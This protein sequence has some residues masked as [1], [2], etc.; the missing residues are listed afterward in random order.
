M[1]TDKE[2]RPDYE[3]IRRIRNS[4]DA[5]ISALSEIAGLDPKSDFQF[6]DLRGVDWRD[7][8]RGD[9][10][11]TG[12]LLDDSFVKKA[13]DEGH[14]FAGVAV[15]RQPIVP[16]PNLVSLDV[17]RTDFDIGS[18]I[19][20]IHID[21]SFGTERFF[22]KV[23]NKTL[24]AKVNLS[25]A[26]IVIESP[27]SGTLRVLRPLNG[28]VTNWTVSTGETSEGLQSLSGRIFGLEFMR[29]NSKKR[30]NERSLTFGQVSFSGHQRPSGYA[31]E[32]E[33][34]D[35]RWLEGRPW[36]E[37]NETPAAS[38][39]LIGSNDAIVED[40]L[41]RVQCRREDF[42][43]RE[44]KPEGIF[45]STTE[46]AVFNAL[47]RKLSDGNLE[48]GNLDSDYSPILLAEAVPWTA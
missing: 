2:F 31:I 45:F 48:Q 32:F 24:Q 6:S 30:V 37:P 10:D 42:V 16:F 12:S 20:D 43:F 17:W 28:P 39:Q 38:V 8:N 4:E 18:G 7:T 15:A 29:S 9:Y 19:S 21:L 26:E 40:I 35:D 14:H 1:K 41:V 22:A 11:T 34:V 47:A 36:S 23:G 25:K 5:T 44:I 46:K 3:A 27:A 33:P 13:I